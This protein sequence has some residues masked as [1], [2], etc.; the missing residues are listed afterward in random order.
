MGHHIGHDLATLDVAY[1]QRWGFKLLNRSLDT[2]YL[3][4]HLQNAGSFS[5][6][7]QI[8]DFTL[9]ALC[10]LFGVVPH[11]RHTAGGDAFLT[12]EVFLRLRPLALRHGREQL[13]AIC[14]P[15]E[16]PDGP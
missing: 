14:E 13:A 5:G 6:R 8:R 1:E 12:A 4:R 10:E 2:A 16:E 3:A 11:G 7:P 15:C 9:D